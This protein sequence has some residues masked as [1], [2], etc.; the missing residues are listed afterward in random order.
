MGRG[1]QVSDAATSSSFGSWWCSVCCFRSSTCFEGC[2]VRGFKL[3]VTSSLGCILVVMFVFPVCWSLCRGGVSTGKIDV[4]SMVG[5][6]FLVLASGGVVM[7][8][9]GGVCVVHL[10]AARFTKV[11]GAS[12][13]WAVV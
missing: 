12:L 4:L 9:C 8:D 10:P 11:M 7:A 2:W 1:V 6:S 13:D 5:A 3:G